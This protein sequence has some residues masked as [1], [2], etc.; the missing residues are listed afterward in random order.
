MK[1]IL[2]YII[3]E[4]SKLSEAPLLFILIFFL[5]YYASKWRYIRII[6][7]L[8]VEKEKNSKKIVKK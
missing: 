6:D 3:Q 4:W 7:I 5:A 1:E 8:S 2:D